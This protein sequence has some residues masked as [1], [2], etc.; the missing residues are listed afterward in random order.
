MVLDA[1]GSKD[2][3][4]GAKYRRLVDRSFAKGLTYSSVRVFAPSATGLAQCGRWIAE[5]EL[6]GWMS[7]CD[8]GRKHGAEGEGGCKMQEW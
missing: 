4:G 3:G 5:G 8:S 6:A 1:V 7:G 2:N